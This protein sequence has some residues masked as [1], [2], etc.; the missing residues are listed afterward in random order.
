M[1]NTHFQHIIL[2]YILWRMKSYDFNSLLGPLHSIYLIF[3]SECHLIDN[4]VSWLIGCQQIDSFSSSLDCWKCVMW[5]VE[6]KNGICWVY[7]LMQNDEKFEWKLCLNKSIFHQ[8]HTK[9]PNKHIIKYCLKLK[10]LKQLNSTYG[11]VIYDVTL[12]YS[13]QFW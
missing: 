4:N 5:K 6:Y 12:V 7:Y 1:R 9:I 13:N 11:S 10:S 2:E 8:F 3:I